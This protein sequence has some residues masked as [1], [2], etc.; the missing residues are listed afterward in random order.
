MSDENEGT[1]IE[2]GGIKFTGGKMMILVT[3]LSSAGGALWGGFEFYKDYMDMKEQIQNYV[4]PDLSGIE[5]K[6]AVTQ[7][8]VDKTV[9]YTQD[10]KNDLKDDI[11]S[12]ESIVENMERSNRDLSREVVT[13]IKDIRKDVDNT[14]RTINTDMLSLEKDMSD[15]LNQL[16]KV[17]QDKIEKA[18]DNPL[19]N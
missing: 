11:R 4:A 1:S 7:E 2:I 16:E 6:V 13:D 3:A 8:N 19:A 17:L 5:Q 9:E 10:I 14:L 12:L 18:L 15:R